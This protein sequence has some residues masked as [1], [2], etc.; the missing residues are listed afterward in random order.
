VPTARVAVVER[1]RRRVGAAMGVVFS[2]STRAMT[3]LV[4]WATLVTV[5]MTPSRAA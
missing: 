1:N 4:V 2:E 5:V 3:Y